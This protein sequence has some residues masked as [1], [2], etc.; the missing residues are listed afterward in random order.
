MNSY[1]GDKAWYTFNASG[2]G[3]SYFLSGSEFRGP[4]KSYNAFTENEQCGAFIDFIWVQREKVK[5]HKFASEFYR[6]Q[7]S[8]KRDI[9]C[10]FCG[11]RPCCY[12]ILSWL[13]LFGSGGRFFAD[14]VFDDGVT[15]RGSPCFC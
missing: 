4:M 3:D 12:Y 2:M 10:V 11:C 8:H 7:V 1:A 14:A 5:V 6:G 15:K 9:R 13:L